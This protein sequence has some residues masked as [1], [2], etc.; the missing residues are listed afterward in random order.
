MQQHIKVRVPFTAYG[1]K[2]DEVGNSEI[3]QI[4]IS[5]GK[6]TI[7]SIQFVYAEKYGVRLSKVFGEP[8]GF[9]FKP[10]SFDYP[11]ERLTSVSGKYSS[12]GCG[13]P[14]LTTLTLCTNKRNYG[15]FGTFEG[16]TSHDFNYEFG[17]RGFG[18]FH[19]SVWNKSICCIGV[20]FK[21]VDKLNPVKDE[22]D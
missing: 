14:R 21:P 5:Y 6:S 17:A 1:I 7:N 13:Y 18:G 12:E 4:L 8:S 10:V 15:P 2:W 20:Y 16:R 3:V 9:N 11:S 19:G 22:V